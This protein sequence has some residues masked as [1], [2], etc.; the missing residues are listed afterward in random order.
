MQ[1]TATVPNAAPPQT[2][3][4]N[5]GRLAD[6]L[7]G[8]LLGSAEAAITGLAGIDQARPGDQDEFAGAEGEVGKCDRGSW[9]HVSRSGSEGSSAVTCCCS[10]G[11]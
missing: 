11:R 10:S 5:A 2:S 9:L 8:E 4:M 3:G 7:G 6:I 1:A